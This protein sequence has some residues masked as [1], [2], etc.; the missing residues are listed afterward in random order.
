MGAKR[1]NVT[2]PQEVFELIRKTADERYEGNLSRYLADAGLYYA[3]VLAGRLEG[4]APSSEK[5][6]RRDTANG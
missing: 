6:R 4:K 2:V 1:L 5:E 3:G